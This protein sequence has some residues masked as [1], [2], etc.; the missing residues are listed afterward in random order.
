MGDK[1][2]KKRHMASSGKYEEGQCS[3]SGS[4]KGSHSRED[5]GQEGAE[6]R[7]GRSQEEAPSPYWLSLHTT[8]KSG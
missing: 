2:E 5:L 8:R 4:F 6:M 1:K 3:K 7:W